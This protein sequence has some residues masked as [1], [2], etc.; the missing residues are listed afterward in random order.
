MSVW[1]GK[2]RKQRGPA[3]DHRRRNH[4]QH[5][6]GCIDLPSRLRGLATD[7]RAVA[8]LRRA[9]SMSDGSSP[10]L[11]AM[12][13]QASSNAWPRAFRAFGP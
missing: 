5:E 6:L 4:P 9:R 12:L 13:A 8:S 11:P 1:H 7:S 2:N 3:G 10:K